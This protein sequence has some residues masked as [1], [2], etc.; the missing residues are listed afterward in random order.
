MLL[1]NE[2]IPIWGLRGLISVFAWTHI[3]LDTVPIRKTITDVIGRT[4]FDL[5]QP[6]LEPATLIVRAPLILQFFPKD[7]IILF[8]YLVL[9]S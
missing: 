6:F 5:Q 8:D 2:I 7:L 3:R 9:A 4:V 1:A